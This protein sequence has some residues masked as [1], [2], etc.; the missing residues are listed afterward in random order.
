MGPGPLGSPS[1]VPPVRAAL[2]LRPFV[3]PCVSSG[4]RPHA[5][6]NCGPRG[7]SM[8][9][10]GRMAASSELPSRL[11]G[12]S[13]A[14]P[15]APGTDLRKAGSRAWASGPQAPPHPQP[16]CPGLLIPIQGGHAEAGADPALRSC[17]PGTQG[18]HCEHPES[19]CCAR[20]PPQP[21]PN[22]DLP[23]PHADP[24]Q[25]S[26]SCALGALST[27]RFS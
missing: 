23:G 8:C 25:L 15:H 7:I 6:G 11:G 16:W 2:V 21:P 27:G 17:P 19:S 5:D 10:W 20:G 22:P 3:H 12:Q 1:P 26:S 24:G 18:T 4:R 14:L 9:N 13:H